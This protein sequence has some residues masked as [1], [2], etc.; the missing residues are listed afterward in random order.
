MGAGSGQGTKH[1]CTVR[2]QQS[3][4]EQA[5]ACITRGQRGGRCRLVGD[6]LHAAHCR[7]TVVKVYSNVDYE[8]LLARESDLEQV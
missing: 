6:E 3:A 7:L 2:P 4:G 1:R 5:V 8:V